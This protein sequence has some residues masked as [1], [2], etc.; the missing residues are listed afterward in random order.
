MSTAPEYYMGTQGFA[1]AW[2]ENNISELVTKLNAADIKHYDTAALY[3]MD[4]IGGSERLIGKV[5]QADFVIDTKIL[6]R[7][8]AL[9]KD[10][11]EASVRSSLDNLGVEKVSHSLGG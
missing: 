9:Q 1:G 8:E 2:K 11:M 10:N 5:R 6:L 4:N 7:P 3:P